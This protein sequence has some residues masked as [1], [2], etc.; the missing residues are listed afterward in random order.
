MFFHDVN[1]MAEGEHPQS[2]RYVFCCFLKSE[3]LTFMEPP[4]GAQYC[5]EGLMDSPNIPVGS[6]FYRR[7]N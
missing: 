4:L 6:P 7:G 2:R 5:A 3:E 1:L